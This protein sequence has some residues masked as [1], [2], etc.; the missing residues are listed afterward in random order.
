LNKLIVK[1]FKKIQQ[2]QQQQQQNTNKREPTIFGSRNTSNEQFNSQKNLNKNLQNLKT[3]ISV[4]ISNLSNAL[5]IKSDVI[6]K[7][8]NYQSRYNKITELIKK[9]GLDFKKYN[10]TLNTIYKEIQKL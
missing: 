9:G 10:P 1:I 4:L 2:Q 5:K 8:Q 3:K 6:G 7:K